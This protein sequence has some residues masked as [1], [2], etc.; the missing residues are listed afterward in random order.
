MLS[1]IL[2]LGGPVF[3]VG[4]ADISGL[5]AIVDA[6]TSMRLPI[7]ETVLDFP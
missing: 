4:L 6:N 1:V 7:V 2:K 5:A 3:S